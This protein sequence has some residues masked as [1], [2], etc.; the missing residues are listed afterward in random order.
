MGILMKLA[1]AITVLFLCLVAFVGLMPLGYVFLPSDHSLHHHIEDFMRS[2][3]H[4]LVLEMPPFFKPLLYYH[5]LVN[6]PL[7]VASLYGFIFRKSWVSTTSL[8]LGVAFA[9]IVVPVLG[10]LVGSGKG[11]FELI[12]VYAVLFCLAVVVVFRSLVASAATKTKTA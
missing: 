9:S 8:I 5:L 7:A 3:Q 2:E 1:D 12:R 10:E 6:W 4:Y 11:S